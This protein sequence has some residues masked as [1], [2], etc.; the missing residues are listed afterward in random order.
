[1]KFDI[2]IVYT[3]CSDADTVWRSKREDAARACGI[4]PDSEGN[5]ECRFADNDDLKYSFRSL[6]LYVP[7]VRKVF[8]VID[9]DIT[10]PAWLKLDHPRL[11]IVRLGEIMPKPQRP[12]FCSDSI[13]HRLA[14]IPDLAEHYLYSNDD[15]LFGRRLRPSFFFTRKGYPVFRFGKLRRGYNELPCTYLKNLDMAERLVAARHPLLGRELDEALRRYPHHCIDAY[16]KRDVLQTYEDFKAAIEPQ[17]DYPF[18]RDCN[19][20]RL[21]YALDAIARGH[22]RFRLARFRLNDRPWYK[23]LLRPGYA[24]SLQFY[25]DGWQTALEAL[26]RFRPG[27]FCF[28]DTETKIESDRRWLRDQYESLFPAASS[29]EKELAR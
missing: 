19:V 9:D 4:G 12:C 7:W 1:M 11:R 5:A 27:M 15:C 3:W 2:D 17:F 21:I 23:R 16:V 13:E 6:E 20:Q 25:G 22:G 29:F 10:P 14:F 26:R 28:N 18:R 8:L 24:D